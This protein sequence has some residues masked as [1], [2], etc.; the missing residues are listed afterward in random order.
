[1]ACDLQAT[2]DQGT[3]TVR[4]RDTMAQDRVPRRELAAYLAA[5]LRAID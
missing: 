5:R 1:M 4:H 2:V 3:V